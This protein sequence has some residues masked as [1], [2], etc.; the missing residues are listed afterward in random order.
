MLT[1]KRPHVG[2]QL[3]KFQARAVG[4]SRSWARRRQRDS[5]ERAGGPAGRDA[6]VTATPDP[7]PAGKGLRNLPHRPT[8]VL[9]TGTRAE[10][11]QGKSACKVFN[12]AR[13]PERPGTGGAQRGDTGRREKEGSPLPVSF[14]R[15]LSRAVQAPSGA[16]KSTCSPL[17]KH[18]G[19]A[20]RSPARGP[21]V[22]AGSPRPGYPTWRRPAARPQAWSPPPG[23][24]ASRPQPPPR[25]NVRLCSSPRPRTWLR[26]EWAR[27]ER[28]VRR[29]SRRPRR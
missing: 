27:H 14:R 13:P 28:E 16:D 20:G 23:G 19:T 12:A 18:P 25:P 29:V 24:F 6:T 26:L 8:R 15:D 21:G 10:A 11:G 17:R 7:K 3:V 5:P 2:Y 9:E 4:V 22:V 1:G